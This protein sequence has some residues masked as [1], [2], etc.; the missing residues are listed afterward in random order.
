MN[1]IH[2]TNFN[3]QYE[4]DFVFITFICSRY[5]KTASKQRAKKRRLHIVNVQATVDVLSKRNA[6]VV[7]V[8]SNGRCSNVS[9]QKCRTHRCGDLCVI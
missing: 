2:I 6:N 3:L 7:A 9:N 8:C 5:K 1:Y 4:V